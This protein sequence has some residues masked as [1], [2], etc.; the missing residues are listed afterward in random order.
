MQ[1]LYGILLIA[2]IYT[3]WRV[4]TNKGYSGRVFGLGAALFP[5]LF[6]VALI[7]PDKNRRTREQE[8]AEFRQLQ[9]RAR[10]KARIDRE[11]AQQKA[12]EEK[13]ADVF[14]PVVKNEPVTATTAD[15]YEYAKRFYRQ[16]FFKSALERYEE[17]AATGHL[18]SQMMCAQMYYTGKGCQKN[19]EK[20]LH[21][22]Q[23]AA[24]QD[25]I[26][27]LGNC[28]YMYERGQGCTADYEKAFYWLKKAAELGD[29]DAQLTTGMWYELGRGCTEDRQKARYW[30]EKAAAQGDANARKL[31]E[32][33][34]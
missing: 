31:L 22:Y 32:E 23:R 33:M 24:L 12:A 18:E 16:G 6:L 7:L 19:Y 20:A 30:Y 8:E 29:S 10:V 1:W 34:K 5:P 3:S 14:P 21:W 2:A 28:S 9:A 17:V 13:A 15:N 11:L 27:A 25:Q 4:G 26:Q